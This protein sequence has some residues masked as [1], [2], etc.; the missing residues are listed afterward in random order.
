MSNAITIKN[1]LNTYNFIGSSQVVYWDLLKKNH[2]WHNKKNYYVIEGHIQYE[3]VS[4][5]A[6]LE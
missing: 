2:N 5:N 1:L 6:T 4:E 3:N